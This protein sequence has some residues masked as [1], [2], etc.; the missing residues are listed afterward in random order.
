MK[1]NNYD[2]NDFLTDKDFISWVKNKDDS[3]AYFFSK[4]LDSNPEHK[5]RAYKA[6]DFLLT[7]KPKVLD[8]EPSEFDEVLTR[9]MRYQEHHS[10]PGNYVKNPQNLIWRWAAIVLLVFSLTYLF[11]QL[12]ADEENVELPVINY[13]TKM[14]PP[15]QRSQIQLPDGSFVHL[16]ADSKLEYA[17]DF[18][19]EHRELTLFGEAY[20]EVKK[21]DTIPFIVKAE[22]VYTKVLGTTF[23][24][25][26]RAESIA[27]SLVEGEVEVGR[28]ETGHWQ[29]TTM[30]P[31]EK[32]I[33]REQ[34]LQITA[35]D[36]QDIAWKEGVIIFENASLDEIIET[37][38]NW[39]GVNIRLINAPSSKWHYNNKFKQGSLELVLERMSYTENFTYEIMNDLITIKF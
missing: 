35:Y 37:L 38:E 11:E 34:E 22:E 2:I 15:G 23:N 25:K 36:F 4:W 18:G 17:E 5:A 20:F 16:N 33:V 14:N 29:K 13:I 6:R 10:E 30:H 21:N 1:Y 9:L 27:I 7:L 24:I 32:V 28:D 3:R 19:V 31:G 12:N 26:A 8:A 39:Y